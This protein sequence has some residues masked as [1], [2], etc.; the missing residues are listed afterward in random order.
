M[1][2]NNHTAM[3]LAAGVGK[4]MRPLTNSTP[5]ALILAGRKP[6]II[7]HLENLEAAGF[8]RV[9]IN[10]FHLGS[11]IEAFLKEKNPTKLKLHFSR[12]KRLLETAGGIAN[13]L[14]TLD[15]DSFA[16]INSDIYTEYDFTGLRQSISK[17]GSTNSF[18][19]HLIMVENPIHNPLGDYSLE[20]DIL[21]N[22]NDSKLTFT[23]ISVFH[24]IFFKEVKRNETRALAP[25][26]NKF[27]FQQK[28][29]GE[30]FKG[31]WFD[32]GTPQRLADL[33]TY[34]SG[35]RK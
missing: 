5:K 31:K 7:H 29:C 12:E 3:I 19:G 18:L 16:V 28:I 26:L 33:N 21:S 14:D 9:V 25:L 27:I 23:G 1:K 34:L 15:V 17:I 13:A 6:L 2:I 20:N 4:R 11:K 10:L 35:L 8:Q 30:H 24:R 22:N 32:V